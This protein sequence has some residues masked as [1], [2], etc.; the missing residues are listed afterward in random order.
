M[1]T[2]IVGAGISG[3]AAAHTLAKSGVRSI[4]LDPRPR[5]GGVIETLHV[6]GMVVDGGPDSFLSAKPEALALAKELG[7]ESD[8]ISSQDQLR[9]TYILRNGRM[10]PMPDGM[11]MMIP[12]KILPI[13]ASP[14]LSWP[15]KMRMALEYFHKPTP[16][17]GD[18][19]VADF[20]AAHYG[21][22]TVDYLAEPLLSG[23]YGGDPAQMSVNSVLQRFVDIET[24]Y[25]SLTKG[26][27][28]SRGKSN[29]AAPKGAPPPPLFRT[30]RRGLG[31]I[32]D[33]IMAATRDSVEYRQ[34]A[35]E[36]IDFTGSGVRVR[37]SGD[38]IE[39]DNIIVACPAHSAAPLL[40]GRMAEILS[41]VPYTSS[42][43]VIFGFDSPPP[44]DGFGFLVP[45]KERR[46]L[47]ACTW[48]GT[49]FPNR[50][51][52]GFNIARCFLTGAA[53]PD[54]D[55]VLAELHSLAKF[56]AKPVFTRVCRWPR[57]MAQYV[58]GHAARMRELESLV[59]QQPKLQLAGNAY[60][61]IGIPDCIRT[62][63]TAAKALLPSQ[64]EPRT[65]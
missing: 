24:K 58:V 40:G 41:A 56:N 51:R 57:A 9:K 27:L 47:L 38:W 15:T 44:M 36:A 16:P 30:M 21:Q 59:A 10:I 63:Q 28:A 1:P 49:K 4:L 17:N 29:P 42:I 65:K 26:V 19:S 52:E 39:G 18:R 45:K 60:K 23:V 61:G 7:L 34:A 22:E 6:D 50:A 20:I 12:T 8:V 48:V 25:G 5:P 11:M 37:A 14:L 53:H 46:Q 2:L 33:A 62:G 55:A 32:I 3:L 13:A 35:V 64:T 31:Q 54:V 43:V